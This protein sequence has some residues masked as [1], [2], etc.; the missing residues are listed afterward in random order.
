M[1]GYWNDITTVYFCG[2]WYVFIDILRR[3]LWEIS[4]S[5]ITLNI[6]FHTIAY[7]NHRKRLII[8]LFLL[9]NWCLIYRQRVF[10][11]R[12]ISRINVLCRNPFTWNI[13]GHNPLTRNILCRDSFF[14]DILCFNHVRNLPLRNILLNLIW[15]HRSKGK[16]LNFVSVIQ[17]FLSFVQRRKWLLALIWSVEIE[18]L[19][20]YNR[21]YLSPF[22]LRTW[23]C[24][25]QKLR[26]I[27]WRS[28][29]MSQIE[30]FVFTRWLLFTYVGNF[31][32][33][34]SCVWAC[35]AW[36]RVSR[37]FLY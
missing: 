6:H 31:M 21:I 1:C 14:R 26:R 10:F 36:M 4:I 20:G 8:L 5:L 23:W 28:C 22:W 30:C 29:F 16:S 37:H 17:Y 35:D 11:W 9:R 19:G 34:L 25:I 32:S 27:R 3:I 7:Q 18:T 15:D 24:S 2:L 12:I 33:S 13:L